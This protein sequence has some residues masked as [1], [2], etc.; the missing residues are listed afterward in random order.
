M[1]ADSFP[2]MPLALLVGLVF[3]EQKN[4]CTRATAEGIDGVLEGK[5]FGRGLSDFSCVNANKILLAIYFGQIL[6]LCGARVL[7]RDVKHAIYG[8][9]NFVASSELKAIGNLF[10]GEMFLC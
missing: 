4:N 6:P 8:D 10:V 5:P 9:P 1:D 3:V 7:C 2:H